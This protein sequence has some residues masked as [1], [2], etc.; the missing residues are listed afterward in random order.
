MT[1]EVTDATTE[2]LLRFWDTF[3]L[4]SSRMGCYLDTFPSTFDDLISPTVAG[5]VQVWV[6][7]H[8][9]EM[10]GLYWL[11]DMNRWGGQ[12]TTWHGIYLFPT[13]RRMATLEWSQ[14]AFNLTEQA[15]YPSIFGAISITNEIAQRTA[16]KVGFTYAG[17]VKHFGWFAGKLEDVAIYSYRKGDASEAMRQGR[18]RANQNRMNP[19]K[20]PD[21][22][23]HLDNS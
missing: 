18:L 5:K 12:G 3:N 2:D 1:T 14:L 9:D 15:G 19:S 22:F 11:H 21:S 16:Q 20:C 17:R 23:R 8:E 4:D 6:F 13:Y 10:A 7:R